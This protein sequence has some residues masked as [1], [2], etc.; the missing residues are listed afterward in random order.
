MQKCKRKSIFIFIIITLFSLVFIALVLNIS[1]HDE[2]VIGEVYGAEH[3]YIRIGE[4]T[5]IACNNPGVT[6]ST[7]RN[8]KLGKVVFRNEE[9]DSMTVW[10][11]DGYDDNEYI[12]VLWV[13]EGM[14]YKKEK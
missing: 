2:E 3:E 13:Y 12:Y 11:I 7:E 8:K 10:S 1:R 9:A 5:Y 4:E 6:I 14:F